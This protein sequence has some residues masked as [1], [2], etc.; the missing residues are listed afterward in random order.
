MESPSTSLLLPSPFDINKERP[1]S[2]RLVFDPTRLSNEAKIPGQFVWP[3]DERSN[4][5]EE[6]HAP[7]VDFGAFLQGDDASTSE[8]AGLVRTACLSHGFF[9]VINH[10]IDQDLVCDALACMDVLFRMPLESKMRAK[11]QPGSL[12][13]YAGGHSDR[14]ASKLPWKETLSFGHNSSCSKPA[15]VDY[16]TST[17]G[18]EFEQVG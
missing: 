12:W 15:V 7:V 9:Q 6:L 13:G 1:T 16:F 3:L 11:R 4:T 18:E 17:L 2:H 5:L 8:V 10:G 14:F